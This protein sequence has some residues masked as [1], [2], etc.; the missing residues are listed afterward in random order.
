MEHRR[1][2]VVVMNDGALKRAGDR[3][4]VIRVKGGRS[5]PVFAGH[6][7]LHLLERLEDHLAVTVGVHRI[8][9]AADE[10][11]H[12]IRL[13]FQNRMPHGRRVGLAHPLGRGR[14]APL[15]QCDVANQAIAGPRAQL[16]LVAAQLLFALLLRQP[17]V[18]LELL[19]DRKLQAGTGL[20]VAAGN[21]D[22]SANRADDGTGMDSRT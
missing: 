16:E 4:D 8:R 17:I 21:V 20:D 19:V 3:H 5:H 15:V 11:A 18:A 12:A 22:V 2:T 10:G 14:S 7:E 1:A 9:R 13:A 6:E